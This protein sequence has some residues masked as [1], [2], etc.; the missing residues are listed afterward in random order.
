VIALGTGVLILLVALMGADHPPPPGFVAV[1][2]GALALS[3]VIALALPRWRVGSARHPWRR[4]AVEGALTGPAV[5]LLVVLL[6]FS[7]EPTVSPTIADHLIGVGLAA[8]LGAVGATAL[9]RI[10]R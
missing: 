2:V 8:T 4:P 6:P 9:A 1:V 3:L 5:W 10:A 7:G